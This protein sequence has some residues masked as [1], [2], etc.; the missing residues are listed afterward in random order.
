MS[1]IYRLIHGYYVEPGFWILPFLLLIISSAVACCVFFIGIITKKNNK[2]K[3]VSKIILAMIVITE[4]LAYA[5]DTYIR[6]N[7]D[8]EK[9][10]QS[11]SPDR[12][13]L[14]KMC[15]L[16]IVLWGNDIHSWLMIYDA[17]TMTLLKEGDAGVNLEDIHW[18]TGENGKTISAHV[19]MEE[20]GLILK[21]PPTWLDKLRAKLP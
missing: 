17:K 9:C 14:G 10:S 8:E 2:L 16:G 13:Y 11:T 5:E 1:V 12:V 15:R 7:F 20:D 3:I 19:D 4:L 21:L 6:T 18:G